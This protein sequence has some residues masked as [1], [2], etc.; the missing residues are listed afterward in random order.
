MRNVRVG[1]VATAAVLLVVCAGCGGETG[2]AQPNAVVQPPAPPPVPPPAPPPLP[3]P[4]SVHANELGDVPVLMY[5]R[6]TA[7]PNSVYDRTPEDFRAELERLAAD[8]YVPVTATEYATARVDIPAGKHP[9]VLTF[10]DG[11]INQ[12][13]LD[14][15]S[16][17]VAGTGVGIL[18]DV[19][20]AHPDF[21]PVAT[22]YVNDPPFEEPTGRR[23]LAWLHEHGFEIGNHTLDHANLGRTSDAE[24]RHQIAG[25]QRFITDAVPGVQVRSIALPLGVHPKNERLAADGSA[26]GG[27]YHHDS[28]MLVGSNPAPSPWSAAFDPANVPRIRSQGPTGQDA[29]YG[30]AAW[31]DKLAADPGRRYTSDGDPNRISAPAD[32]KTAPSA[33]VGPLLYEY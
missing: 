10:D 17:L 9:V 16:E 32:R 25:M 4:E 15:A 24:V 5:H 22:C 19:A 31:L 11:S 3:A 2:P 28:V 30:S 23:T 1:V 26:D 7:T 27:D 20:A 33:A 13:T 14:G 6:I 29:Q 8:D 12:F 18:L 21:R